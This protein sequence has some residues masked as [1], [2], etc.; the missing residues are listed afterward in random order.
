MFH[1]QLC[2]IALA[3]N[4]PDPPSVL[5]DPEDIK[6]YYHGDAKFHYKSPNIGFGE[7]MGK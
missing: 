1:L 5:T 4:Q 3:D 7:Y 2:S 6:V